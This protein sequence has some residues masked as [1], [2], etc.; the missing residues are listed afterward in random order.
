MSRTL[1]S[2]QYG[3]DDLQPG[4]RIDAGSTVVTEDI[5][6]RFADLSG[7]RFE[8]HMDRQAA[9]RHGFSGRVA[10]GLCVLALVDGLKN[11]A[12]AQF[13]AQASLGWNW[14]FRAPVI[15]GDIISVAIE[16]VE[17]RPV[18][19]GERGILRLRFQITNQDDQLVQEGENL[20]MAYR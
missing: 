5:I 9:A 20:L 13:K 7:D 8:I 1:V 12:P 15:A 2:G 17:K 3:F 16:V 6:D 19:S 11:Q 18:K 14:S 10:H 4:D